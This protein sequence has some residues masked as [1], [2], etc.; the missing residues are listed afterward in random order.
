[1]LHEKESAP[2]L[3]GKRASVSKDQTSISLHDWNIG[4]WSFA[5][6]TLICFCAVVVMEVV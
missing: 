3:Q 4:C 5:L 1:M 2:S 6:E